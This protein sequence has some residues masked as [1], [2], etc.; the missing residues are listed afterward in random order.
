MDW[1]S[2]VV[3]VITAGGALLGTYFANRKA[4]GL[5]E[6]RLQKLEEKVSMHNNVVERVYKLEQDAAVFDEK[7]KVANHRIDD[8]E[9][10]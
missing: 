7:I 3:A 1:T 5:I 9:S 8:L 4:Q 10:R 6:Y 2:I